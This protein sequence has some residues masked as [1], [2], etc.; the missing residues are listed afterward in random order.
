M[1]VSLLSSRLLL[2]AICLAR[3][4]A[5]IA[6]VHE[7]CIHMPIIHSTNPQYLDKRAV[8][9]ELSNRSDIAYY[10]K[11]TIGNPGQSVLVQLDT[12]SFELWVNPDCTNLSPANARF[13]QTVGFYDTTKSSTA[14][15]LGTSRTLNY[16]I[17]SANIS[18]F[19]DDIALPGS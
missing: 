15:P 6:S 5:Q 3:V 16:G 10:A 11:L 2:L 14:V 19:T 18:Y 7:G 13:C 8:S 17:G 4:A 9:V 12:G 1:A